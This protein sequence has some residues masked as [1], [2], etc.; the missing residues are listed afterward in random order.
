MFSHHWHDSNSS[1][2]T[3]VQGLTVYWLIFLGGF[4]S[5]QHLKGLIATSSFHWWRKTPHLWILEYVHV[6][7]EP[8][9]TTTQPHAVRGCV[10]TSQWALPREHMCPCKLFLI[11]F[12]LGFQLHQTSGWYDDFQ[13]LL[14]VQT[15]TKKNLVPFCGCSV[16]LISSW[17]SFY[18]FDIALP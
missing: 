13:L 14:V 12:L 6:W 18:T 3:D 16:I 15:G 1:S 8:G 10:V 17:N 9:R 11:Y 4:Q 7:V 5:N 2:M